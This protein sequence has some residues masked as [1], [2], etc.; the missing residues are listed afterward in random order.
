MTPLD[1]LADGPDLAFYE[2]LLGS[3]LSVLLDGDEVQ[4]FPVSDGPLALAF[5]TDDRL[6]A[7]A[8]GP[9]DRAVMPGRALVEMLAGQG[10]GIGLNLPEAPS[11]R[12]IPA[13]A[14]DW[15][16]DLLSE[17]ARV[18]AT[19]PTEVTAPTGLSDRLLAALDRRLAQAEGLADHAWLAGGVFGDGPARLLL[20]VVGATKGAED[21]LG[22]S[23]GEAVVF[24]GNDGQTVDL[25][26]LEH[27]DP[28]IGLLKKVGLRFDIPA[29]NPL[30]REAPGTN[31]LKPP[32][33]R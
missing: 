25:V 32:R 18:Q 4:I 26:F 8:E 31:P 22:Q 10:L 7:F 24:V 20:A 33:L 19:A 16:A 11:A 6:A 29:P 2:A 13:D 1:R 23:I 28:L 9:A 12:V 5:E 21:S 3:E 15:L 17:T 14:V 30:K 27:S